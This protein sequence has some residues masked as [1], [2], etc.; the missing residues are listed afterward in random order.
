MNIIVYVIVFVYQ[1][2]LI[3]LGYAIGVSDSDGKM[4]CSGMLH[5]NET[6]G[7]CTMSKICA[8]ASTCPC[9]PAQT[10]EGCPCAELCPG[11]CEGVGPT[12]STTTQLVKNS[13]TYQKTFT[14]ISE[15]LDIF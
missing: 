2:L 4:R 5:I 8:V 15:D 7:G 14:E 6:K 3:R 12:Y 1:V 10:T 13:P 11:Y 9:A